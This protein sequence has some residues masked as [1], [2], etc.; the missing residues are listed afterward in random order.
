[1]PTPKEILEAV[2]IDEV[3]HRLANGEMMSEICR[4]LGIDHGSMSWWISSDPSRSARASE[5]RRLSA[6]AHVD[7]G[8]R[9]LL[10]LSGDDTPVALGRAR[11]LASHHRWKAAMFNPD[12]Y[13]PRQTQKHVGPDD[14]P[15][16][17]AIAID[18][19][20]LEPEQRAALRAAL[21]AMRG[22]G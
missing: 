16:Q 13:A 18:P 22:D 11:E 12:R 5:A 6:D 17:H 7:A 14:G 20:D 8:E 9:V 21:V 2:G 15:I 3:C 10:D 19:K 1:M 4:T